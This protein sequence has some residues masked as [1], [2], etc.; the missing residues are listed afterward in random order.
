VRAATDGQG[1]DVVLNSL[2]GAFLVRSL[3]L[4]KPLGR[5]VEIG[6]KDVFANEALQLH[7][8]RAGASFHAVDLARVIAARPQWIGGRLG[9]VLDAV[10]AGTY[11]PL[12]LVTFASSR[13]VEAFRLM[14]QGQ[15]VGKIVITFDPG[16]RPHAIRAADAQ[17]IRPDG[18]YLVTGG[19]TGF[20]W[21]TA[22][23]LVEQG[24]RSVVL[25]SRTA[26]P[27]P[28]VAAR[29]DAW[30][31]QG[32][33]VRVA[34]C[35]VTDRAQVRSVVQAAAREHAP[36]RGVFH[37]A[38]V[39]HDELLATAHREAFAQVLA[40]KVQ[41]AWNLHVETAAL[42]LD[43]FV[44]YSSCATLLGSA[45]QAAYVAANRFV[46]ALAESRRL[47]GL[48]AMAVG[49][50]PLADF[51]VV[52][53]RSELARHLENVG[54]TA[55]GRQTVFDWLKF[56][57]RR[58]ATSV[59]VLQADWRRFAEVNPVAR[60]SDRFS[61]L[62]AAGKTADA[63]DDVPHRLGAAA[64]SE[65]LGIAMAEL[66][67]MIATVLQADPATIDAELPLTNLG[68][69]S[70]MAFELKVRIEGELGLA[71]PLDRLAA[72]DSLHQL[73]GRL[74]AQFEQA[75]GDAAQPQ[76]R[77]APQIALHDDRDPFRIVRRSQ[78]GALEALPLD[79]AALTYLPDKLHTVGG[80]SDARMHAMFGREPFV[81][82]YFDTPFGRIGAVTLPVRS[83]ALFTGDGGHDLIQ[84]A[85]ALAR[86]RGA[87]CVSLT[88]L[89]PS[90]TCYGATLEAWDERRGLELTTGH[91]TTTA[92]V[93]QTLDHALAAGH[94]ALER[95][96]VAVLGVGSI[97]QPFL[98]LMLTVLPHP[99][100]LV[101][102][103]LFSREQAL[104]AFAHVLRAEY[105]FRGRIR[106]AHAPVGAP[107]EVY[108]ATT[109]VAA[110]SASEVLDVDRLQP[111]T[112]VVDDSYPPAFALDRAVR[113][114]EE[115]GDILFSNAGML[116]LPQP[117]R[118]TL[119]VPDGAEAALE[120]FG[121]AAFRD[122][123]ARDARELTACVL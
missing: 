96:R 79:A 101:L 35:D 114:I 57:L 102:C 70:L 2:S 81:T 77:S 49:W 51:R 74:V 123:V 53:Q 122:E 83:G 107:D 13:I 15:H 85:L 97:G 69:D 90:A 18:S 61:A 20:G 45:G 98:R 19:L 5:F 36:L 113:R 120:A 91:A 112:I 116:R 105:R 4:L 29:L 63:H 72:G 117:V 106:V 34:R 42:D 100:E 73:A 22:Q 10:A 25:A 41:G 95:E 46:E 64:P 84:R 110:L 32:V 108:G 21:A 103:D 50:G 121:V 86:R 56:L 23:W 9:R 43:H 71:L 68:L 99:R 52:A 87:R 40:P 109:S 16:A 7:A 3:D 66:R 76:A 24:A 60:A 88:G 80:L 104:E 93:V 14:A 31:A 54:M 94:R 55:L 27:G 89:I 75:S 92:A 48:A 38:M 26:A 59:F 12:P 39:L 78:A 67:G 111:G 11:Q 118:E 58:D 65:R 33:D 115:R 6:K 8:F 62:I 17:P 47:R 44:L 28:L 82:N 37:S 30:R 119:V 1:V